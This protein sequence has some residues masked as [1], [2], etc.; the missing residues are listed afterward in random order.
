VVY[1]PD[2]FFLSAFRS[3]GTASCVNMTDSNVRC[4]HSMRLLSPK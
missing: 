1:A 3:S 4:H 2:H